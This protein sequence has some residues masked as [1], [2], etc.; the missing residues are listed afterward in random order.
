MRLFQIAYVT[1]PIKLEIAQGYPNNR[2]M[3][4]KALLVT[5]Y[6]PP[7][8]NAAITRIINLERALFE[9]GLDVSVLTSGSTARELMNT[10]PE[11]HCEVINIKDLFGGKRGWVLPAIWR[12]LVGVGYV[13]GIP[14]ESHGDWYLRGRSILRKRGGRFDVVLATYPPL[15]ALLLGIFASTMHKCPMISDFRDGLVFEPVNYWRS[16]LFLLHWMT[17]RILEKLIISRSSLVIAVSDQ[18]AEDFIHRYG[19]NGEKSIFATITNGYDGVLESIEESERS[20]LSNVLIVH[21]GSLVHKQSILRHF[22]KMLVIL[23][24]KSPVDFSRIKVVLMGDCPSVVNRMIS[25]RKLSSSI[26]ILKPSSREDAVRLQRKAD[27]LLLFPLNGNRRSSVAT[28]KLY[29]YLTARRPILSFCKNTMAEKVIEL[30]RTG[31]TLAPQNRYTNVNSERLRSIVI[32]AS[33]VNPDIER[34]SAFAWPTLRKKYA[35]ALT[36]LLRKR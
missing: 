11:V 24:E 27:I 35:S 31:W 16:R 3:K 28:T 8:N 4:P 22:L 21:T 30:T 19:E 14:F 5:Y 34:I 26:T 12:F 20:A 25:R 33:T 1:P 7:T 18:I 36:E 6:Y 13:L 17:V 23:Q 15:E 2:N 29:E 9:T 10:T 32:G